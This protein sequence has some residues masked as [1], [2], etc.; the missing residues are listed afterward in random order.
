MAGDQI[1]ELYFVE[2]PNTLPYSV[3]DADCVNNSIPSA[4]SDDS[5]ESEDIAFDTALMDLN[6][7][8]LDKFQ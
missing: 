6:L 2:I 3:L 8:F 5:S 1:C 7:Q 4:L